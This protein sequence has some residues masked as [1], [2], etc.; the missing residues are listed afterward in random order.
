VPM[1]RFDLPSVR[2][3]TPP[4]LDRVIERSLQREP[5]RRYQQA[6]E[7][8]SDVAEVR[9]GLGREQ[10]T[11]PVAADKR[12]AL[13]VRGTRLVVWPLPVALFVLTLVG[14]LGPVVNA[15]V[16][17]A[18][19]S[20]EMLSAPMR[21]AIDLAQGIEQAVFALAPWLLVPL[22]LA[23]VAACVL[24]WVGI[25]WRGRDPGLASRTRLFSYA[26]WQLPWHLAW[27]GL[28]FL[29]HFAEGDGP[30]GLSNWA[31]LGMAVLWV[32]GWI[33][34]AESFRR[35]LGAATTAPLP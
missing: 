31:V 18:E 35:W 11:S 15:R 27:L 28:S 26:A 13:L 1:G 8:G 23:V 21:L 5:A 3:R 6:G 30:Y 14:N 24:G 29:A 16:V 33:A 19:A 2:L 34:I 12:V 32:L 22:M 10:A 17:R 20:S 25:A 4:R 7:V 9:D